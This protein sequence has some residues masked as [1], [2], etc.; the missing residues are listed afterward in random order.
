MRSSVRRP[1]NYE[2]DGP[3]GAVANHKWRLPRSSDGRPRYWSQLV[4][5][6]KQL[7][8]CSNFYIPPAVLKTPSG[9]I[10]SE[11]HDAQSFA[12]NYRIWGIRW[13]KNFDDNHC[14]TFAISISRKPLEIEDW[15]K[16]TTN[17]KWPMGY[18]MVTWTWM[19]TWNRKVKL[20]SPICLERNISKTAADAI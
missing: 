6:G 20:V 17:R 11:F 7:R 2:Y 19:V 14:I 9:M 4:K 16:R 18:Q 12:E 13:W 5:Q 10:Q 3:N 8:K 15:F 1:Q